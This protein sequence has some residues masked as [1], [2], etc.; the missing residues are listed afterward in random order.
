M[1][2]YGLYVVLL[3]AMLADFAY[4]AAKHYPPIASVDD[5]L[6]RLE[7]AKWHP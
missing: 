5:E 6:Q 4:G 2:K 3:F 1:K 7:A